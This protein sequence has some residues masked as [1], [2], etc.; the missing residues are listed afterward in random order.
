[1][2]NI[3][4]DGFCKR[5]AA[6]IAVFGAALV[7][8]SL[9]DGSALPFA[10]RCFG[11]F[12]WGVCACAVLTLYFDMLGYALSAAFGSARKILCAADAAAWLLKLLFVLAPFSPI[13][14]DELFVRF[15]ALAAD[16][17]LSRAHLLYTLKKLNNR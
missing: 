17:L 8:I 1:M 6:A 9:A 3:V 7:G 13:D 11:V 2:E 16:A 14:A 5:T 12:G 4:F 10:A 15:A